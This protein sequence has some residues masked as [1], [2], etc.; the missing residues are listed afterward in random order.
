[1]SSMDS[2]SEEKIVRNIKEKAEILT[3]II[4][5]HRLSTVM[6]ADL[7]YFL[8]GPNEMMVGT[9]KELL[10]NSGEFYGLFAGQIV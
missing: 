2:A 1:M 6:S 5:S 9:G 3:I 8:K 4:V 7:I 10:R